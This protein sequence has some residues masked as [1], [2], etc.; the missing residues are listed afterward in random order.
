[1]PD[2]IQVGD[3]VR[4]TECN[5]TTL[6]GR[7]GTVIRIDA[8]TIP[9]QVDFEDQSSTWASKVDFL[10]R[11]CTCDLYSVLLVTGCRCGSMEREKG[12]REEDDGA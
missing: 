6:V 8:S 3:H 5:S 2:D 12:K 10:G 11:K 7:T 4:I 9:Y 1:M